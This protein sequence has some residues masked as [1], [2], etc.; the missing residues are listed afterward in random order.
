MKRT[1]L[2]LFFLHAAVAATPTGVVPFLDCESFDPSTNLLTAFFGYV[3]SN[4]GNVTASIG[5]NNFVSPAPDNRGEPTVFQPGANPDAWETS[6]DVT[7]TS[8]I[9]WT[10][11]GQSV[12]VSNNPSL[13]CSSC[14]CPLGPTGVQGPQG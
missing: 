6:F 10:V 11:L 12:T 14:I 9:T 2:F 1:L 8:Q 13:Y 7:Q 4:S 5:P 3:S